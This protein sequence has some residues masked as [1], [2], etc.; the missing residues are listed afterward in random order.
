MSKVIILSGLSGS[1]KSTY[2]NKLQLQYKGTYSIVSADHYFTEP[3]GHYHFD[4]GKLGEAHAICFRNY[5]YD[6]QH[7]QT[8][9]I[10]G[11]IVDNTNL[12]E[13]E[14]SP[15]MLGAAAFGYD[16]EIV[17][18]L[19]HPDTAAARNVH[20][21]TRKAIENQCRKLQHRRLPHYWKQTTIDSR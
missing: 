10:V 17:T 3:G 16:A 19:C 4:A 20:G 1:G 5:L 8:I 11:V 6:L 7:G 9:G 18:L 13:T 12:S 21:L 14:I 2:A 15:Y